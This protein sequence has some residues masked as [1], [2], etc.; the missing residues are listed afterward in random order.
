MTHEIRVI[1]SM[2]FFGI[3]LHLTQRVRPDKIGQMAE[4]WNQLVTGQPDG[5]A[6]PNSYGRARKSYLPTRATFSVDWARSHPP[7]RSTEIA[8]A[9]VVNTGCK[10]YGS[11][12]WVSKTEKKI[13][14]KST[15]RGCGRSGGIS[16]IASIR[17][18]SFRSRRNFW[19]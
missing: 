6:P 16:W 3:G 15:L 9:I 1:W 11:D 7:T 12:V 14:V 4:R 2:R 13:G 18:V 17:L 10:T 5:R 19:T 8:L